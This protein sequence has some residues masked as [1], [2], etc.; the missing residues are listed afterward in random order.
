MFAQANS[1]GA[2][3]LFDTLCETHGVT[4]RGVVHAQVI[5]DPADHHV[6]GVKTHAHAKIESTFKA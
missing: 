3:E 5:P 6:P 2:S 4:L 1:L